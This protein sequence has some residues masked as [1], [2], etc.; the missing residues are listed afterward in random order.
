MVADSGLATSCVF[1][2]NNGGLA[3]RET[4]APASPLAGASILYAD[5]TAHQLK[6]AL[7]GGA[8]LTIPQ[9]LTASPTTTDAAW[10]VVSVPNLPSTGHCVLVP[11]NAPAAAN[12]RGT[13]VSA[14]SAASV[15][16]AHAGIAGMLYDLICFAQ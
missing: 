14:I 12:T 1:G 2:F 9:I 10:D 15:M 5:S 4:A 3:I 13:F 7:D 11:R 16:V 8:F 6:S